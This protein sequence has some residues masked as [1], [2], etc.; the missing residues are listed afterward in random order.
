M[1]DRIEIENQQDSTLKRQ[2]ALIDWPIDF[3]SVK[4]QIRAGKPTL[5]VVERTVRLD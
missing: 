3:G 4:I 2:L 5:V 1:P